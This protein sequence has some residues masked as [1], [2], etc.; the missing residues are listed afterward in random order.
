[1]KL[2]ISSPENLRKS[3]TPKDS[4]KESI[5]VENLIQQVSLL[6]QIYICPIEKTVYFNGK[7]LNLRKQL[8]IFRLFYSL[9]LNKEKGLDRKSLIEKVYGV[10]EY[11]ISDRQMSTYHHNIVKLLSR[12]RKIAQ[13]EFG[14]LLF[15]VEWFSHHHST[16]KWFLLKPDIGLLSFFQA[17]SKDFS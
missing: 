7:T 8:K 6:H 5:F 12:S 9:Y 11:E 4:N 14:S 2:R 16:R 3:N 17:D 1:M 15:P 13:T 10:C